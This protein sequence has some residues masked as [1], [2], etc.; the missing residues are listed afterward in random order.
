MNDVSHPQTWDD[1]FC[2]ASYAIFSKNLRLFV[3]WFS[4]SPRSA[5]MWARS[6]ITT[7]HLSLMVTSCHNRLDKNMISF[8]SLSFQLFSSII[9]FYV[10]RFVIMRCL[11]YCLSW[12]CIILNLWMSFFFNPS[13][14]TFR[15]MLKMTRF[16]C[17]SS[18]SITS[19]MNF[20]TISFTVFESNSCYMKSRKY[21][22]FSSE[23]RSRALCMTVDA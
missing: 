23:K 11:F 9:R 20:V 2:W 21:G 8:Y 10:I 4:L 7:T 18:L 17:I 13:K 14:S 22:R 19:M 1:C 6:S 16:E 5:W 15:S 3:R 12:D